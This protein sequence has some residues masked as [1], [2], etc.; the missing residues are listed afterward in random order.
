MSLPPDAPLRLHGYWRS[1]ASYRVRIALN[2]KGLAYDQ[3]THDLRRFA[4]KEARY[5]AIAPHGMVP[6]LESAGRVFIQSGAIIEWLEERFPEP[7]L[8]PAAAADRAVVRAMA[9]LI[10]CDIQP[11]AN[12]RI[13]NAL[14]SDFRATEEQIERWTQR[15][16]EDGFAALEAEVGKY[17]GAYCFGDTLTVADCYLVPQVF[18]A[19]RFGV[20]LRAFA[21]LRAIAARAGALEAVARAHPALQP[22]AAPA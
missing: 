6:A 8:L 11:T 18:S 3:T 20:D 9:G 13:F 1:S 7:P 16:V 21:R 12:M 17:G 19:E 2:V 4:Q 15:W 10:G 5:L 14:R 22:D